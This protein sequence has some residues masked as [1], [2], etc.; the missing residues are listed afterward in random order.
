MSTAPPPSPTEA[1]A[2]VQAALRAARGALVPEAVDTRRA[3]GRVLLR[4][5]AADRD[6]PPFDRVMMDGIAVS[7]AALAGGQR[8]FRRTGI[9]AAGHPAPPLGAADTAVEAMT[10]A[11]LPAGADVVVPVED[12]VQDGEHFT[13]AE[14][15]AQAASAGQN[16]HPRGSDCRAG[17]AV[18]AAPRRLGAVDI[19]IAAGAGA[20][21]LQVAPPLRVAVI[22]TGD[23]LVEAGVDAAPWQVRRS[24]A[25]AIATALRA[26]G[27]TSVSDHHLPDDLPTLEAALVALLRDHDALVLSGGVSKGRFDHV[28]AALAAA[29]VTQVL[30]RVAQRPGQPLWCGVGPQGQAVFGLP[31]NP[32]S[33]LVCVVRYVLPALRALE[34]LPA[35]VAG[36]PVRL[37]AEVRA[38]PKATRFVPVRLAVDAGGTLLAA[39][40]QPSNS[41][42]FLALTDTHGVVE[43]PP[44]TAAVSAG[45][46]LPC[47]RW[48]GGDLAAAVT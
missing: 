44:A 2:L 48:P 32:V 12:L 6:Q 40:E 14:D 7:A 16:I 1:L 3:G 17:D 10:G 21:T 11:M 26:A 18:L 43:V 5:I 38:L 47:W 9:A 27:L 20:A 35:P 24:N 36:I 31:G 13:L 42:D 23:E 30:H 22:S 25:H 41:G 34:G 37:A 19:A 46:V 15:A 8:R 28:P 33:T 39:P 45:T 29:Q 4:G